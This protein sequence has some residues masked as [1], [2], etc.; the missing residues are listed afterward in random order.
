MC[1]EIPLGGRDVDQIVQQAFRSLPILEARGLSLKTVCLPVIGT[2]SAGLDVAGLVR[3]IL[4]GAEWALGV[5][6]SAERVLFVEMDS[7]RAEKMSNAMDDILGRVRINVANNLLGK[8]IKKQIRSKSER[9][10]KSDYEARRVVEY[11]R[12]AVRDESRSADAGMA[13]RHLREYVTMRV[14]NLKSA[15]E[16]KDHKQIFKRLRD[17]KQ[18]AEWVISYL[19]LLRVFGNE[20]VHHKTMNTYP[21]EIV[22]NDVVACLFAIQRVLDFWFGWQEMRLVGSAEIA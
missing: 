15:M 12:R 1:V 5:C 14:L 22:E 16:L 4:Q 9:L 21:Q 13:G 11:L 10:E 18:I 6:G 19:N 17:E 7:D 2:G 20:T 8:E 3:P